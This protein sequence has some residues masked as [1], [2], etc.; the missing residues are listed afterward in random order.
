MLKFSTIDLYPQYFDVGIHC[1]GPT[2][3]G[4][5]SPHMAK[6]AKYASSST[7]LGYLVQLLLTLFL[8]LWGGGSAGG[9]DGVGRGLERG[10][11]RGLLSPTGTGTGTA[12]LKRSVSCLSRSDAHIT[13]T[14]S[15]PRVG[16][17]ENRKALAPSNCY[18]P[19]L[20]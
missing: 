11:F 7:C 15:A 16:T 3:V 4:T 1:F 8:C 18:F 10:A 17:V 12:P 6:M 14:L 5:Q 2:V 9:G 19:L 13:K 20:I